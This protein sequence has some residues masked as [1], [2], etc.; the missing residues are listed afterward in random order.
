[1]GMRQSDQ[2]VT[3]VE[4]RTE[5]NIIAPADSFCRFSQNL[6]WECRRVRVD[7]YRAGVTRGEQISNSLQ[8]ADAKVSLCLQYQVI[9]L[10]KE[11]PEGVLCTRRGVNCIRSDRVS[12]LQRVDGVREISDETRGNRGA[13]FRP[14]WRR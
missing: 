10:R 9:V 1:M 12:I 3:T 8:K 4:G 14:Q 6:G 13:F 5:C 7:Q 11:L 2:G